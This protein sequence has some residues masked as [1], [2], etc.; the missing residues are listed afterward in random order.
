MSTNRSGVFRGCHVF[1]THKA[2]FHLD[3]ANRIVGVESD[4]IKS[5]IFGETT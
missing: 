2:S 5:K 4:T 3:G 1:D